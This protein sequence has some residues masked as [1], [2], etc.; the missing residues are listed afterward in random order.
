[1]SDSS[2]D[3]MRFLALG[4]IPSDSKL[5]KAFKQLPILSSK[6]T[7]KAQLPS[8]CMDSDILY[9]FDWRANLSIQFLPKMFL[10]NSNPMFL[11]LSIFFNFFQK[12]FLSCDITYIISQ[13]QH[14]SLF[15]FQTL[16]KCQNCAR[17]K[18]PL[19]CK[20]FR[21]QMDIARKVTSKNLG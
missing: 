10:I 2:F 18:T 11:Y 9:N 21:S 8:S 14:F 13:A 19:Y 20:L 15:C 4:V 6:I 3:Y 7:Y 1:M 16:I 17:S 5:A 12:K